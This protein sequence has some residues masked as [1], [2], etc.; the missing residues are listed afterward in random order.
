MPSVHPINSF[1]RTIVGSERGET[2]HL[3]QRHVVIYD[4]CGIVV[5][6][7]HRE[8]P[9]VGNAETGSFLT[10]SCL[11]KSSGEVVRESVRT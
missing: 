10:V 6:D 5:P 9:L 1:P 3:M 11:G 4:E 7:Q 2:N 8:F